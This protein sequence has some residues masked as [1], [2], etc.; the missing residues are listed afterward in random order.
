MNIQYVQYIYNYIQYYTVYNDN[1]NSET[2]IYIPDI[3]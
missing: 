1:D 2:Y 3:I